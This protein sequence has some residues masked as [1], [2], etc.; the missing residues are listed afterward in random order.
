MPTLYAT[1]RKERKQI[2][3]RVKEMTSDPSK[4]KDIMSGKV[5]ILKAGE[6]SCYAK[7]QDKVL[8]SSRK[9]ANDFITKLNKYIDDPMSVP[10]RFRNLIKD[11]EEFLK[12]HHEMGELKTVLEKAVPICKLRLDEQKRAAVERNRFYVRQYREQVAQAAKSKSEVMK[13]ASIKI[14]KTIDKIDKVAGKYETKSGIIRE[15]GR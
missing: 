10:G 15:K 5:R 7:L 11:V 2:E 3:E 1:R 9:K 14:A 8:E 4:K 6:S 13:G 12:S